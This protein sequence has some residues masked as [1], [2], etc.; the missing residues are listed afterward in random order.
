[1]EREKE[2][3]G[4]GRQRERKGGGQ[5]WLHEFSSTVVLGEF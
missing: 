5:C 1:M 3:E 2:G 4:G